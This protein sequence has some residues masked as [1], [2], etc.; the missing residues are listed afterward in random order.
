MSF[1]ILWVD[2]QIDELRGHCVYLAE[3]GYEVTG[4]ANGRDALALLRETA[5]DAILLDE[6]MP[7][8]GGLETLAE[9]K[10]IRDT[11]P[12][13]MVTKSEA[14]DLVTRAIG[15]RIDGY[16]VKPVSPLQVL[17][18]L[19]KALEGRRI[20][21]EQVTRDY[22]A[23]FGKVANRVAA[24]ASSDD[25]V[26]LYSDLV[27]WG[28]EL[29]TYSD[30]GLRE[31]H[32]EQMASCNQAL[33]RY[34]RERY[35]DWVGGAPDTPL[36]SPRLF[37]TWVEPE[38]RAG[39]PVFWFLIDCMRLDQ[40]RFV[41]A[42][43][44]PYYRT[45]RRHY[46]SILPSATPFARNALFSGLFP[47]EIAQRYPDWW[48]GSSQQEH[49]KNAYEEELLRA[50]L[51]RLSSPA[52]DDFK[53]YKVFDARDTDNLR[54]Q[55]GSLGGV[56]LVAAV[57]NFL[58]IMAHGRSQ[59]V[60]LKELAPDEA[61]FRSLMSSWFEH[62]TLFEVLKILARRDVTV[63][64][65]TDHGSMFCRRATAVKGNRETSTNVRYKYGDNLAVDE[66]QVFLMKNPEHYMLPR[67]TPIENY[68]I[69]TESYYL[70]YPTNYHEYERLY[71]NS[72]QHGG[73][74]LE[75]LI[76]PFIVLRPR[77]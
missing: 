59:S 51:Q 37:E 58:D 38:I 53:Y 20:R 17:S 50:Q 45:E 28:L 42:L 67:Q 30:L 41:E 1:S 3:K 49:S 16:L 31:T 76:C 10:K 11:V 13:I 62:S 39:K 65:T 33:A 40:W 21:G 36:L 8:M 26:A 68:A 70:V 64:L 15:K 9:I 73:I 35:R 23:H 6:M 74:S 69:T 25:W 5:F 61:A 71:R 48:R 63:L 46:W 54:R 52:A 77:G 12:V 57:Y 19:K 72:F 24:A 43:V 75:E 34:V 44:E 29:Q 66:R 47:L 22:L 7:G 56:R 18:V 32:G 55:I 27:G 2:D 14:E 60:I 4:A